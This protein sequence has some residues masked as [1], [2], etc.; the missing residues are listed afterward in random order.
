[1]EQV[2]RASGVRAFHLQEVGFRVFHGPPV[3]SK[4]PHEVGV[5]ME[6]GDM[7]LACVTANVTQGSP[8]G[9]LKF[10]RTKVSVE[11]AMRRQAANGN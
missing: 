1:M 2:S 4:S 5:D 7:Y 10:A 8:K 11:E 9:L 3:D 6:N